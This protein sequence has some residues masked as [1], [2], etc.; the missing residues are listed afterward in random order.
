MATN[1]RS[2]V[3]TRHLLLGL[4]VANVLCATGVGIATNVATDKD[5]PRWLAWLD[6]G[7][8][9]WVLG[10]LMMTIIA[11]SVAL[12]KLDS[13]PVGARATSA[14]HDLLAEESLSRWQSA[15]REMG[16]FS[17]LPLPSKWGLEEENNG[18]T[19]VMAAAWGQRG[20][21]SPFT[22]IPG[23]KA[24]RPSDLKR[25]GGGRQ[26]HRIYGSLPS[27]RLIVLGDAGSGKSGSAVLLALDAL[28]HRRNQPKEDRFLVP[29]PLLLSPRTWHAK[30]TSTADWLA[31]H[32]ANEY[33]F[34]AGRDG[35]NE[36]EALVREGRVSL[37][38][39]GLDEI[40][41]EFRLS[42]LDALNK[43]TIRVVVLSRPD[44]LQDATGE[45]LISGAIAVR[46]RPFS[47]NTAAD[48]LR[49][50]RRTGHA[51][52]RWEALLGLLRSE[53]E[54]RLATAL[55]SPLA[56]GIVRDTYLPG[57]DA[58]ELLDLA[59]QGDE[60]SNKI[61]DHLIKRLIN[62]AYGSTDEETVKARRSLARIAHE[63][64]ARGVQEL[65][66][67]TIRD[68]SP[69]WP[70][71]IATAVPIAMAIFLGI[72]LG[73]TLGE[74]SEWW[75]SAAA[76]GVLA[77]AFWPSSQ[78]PNRA[79]LLNWRAPWFLLGTIAVAAG[80][81]WLTVW[82]FLVLEV[83]SDAGILMVLYGLAVATF[84]AFLL[85]SFLRWAVRN[86]TR[87]AVSEITEALNPVRVRRSD[88]RYGAAIGLVVGPAMA[89]AASPWASPVAS[90]LLGL[91]W[92]GVVGA[93]STQAWQA[94][95]AFMQMRL[96]WGTSLR[97]M[98]L[99][100]DAR[101]RA[102]L[103]RSVGPIYQFRHKK[104]QDSIAQLVDM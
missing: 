85:Q 67:W 12:W 1:K 31:S 55:N 98:N 61:A 73:T 95:L 78:V 50:S 96:R 2:H 103:V 20:R 72:E 94:N 22:P 42:L 10:I 45:R 47:G 6:G 63:M 49:L 52:E 62:F 81:M 29:V 69:K 102:A 53:P 37:I 15:A 27:G 43:A 60:D 38:L 40:P 28:A 64:N 65:E 89:V 90:L 100:E 104:L 18:A 11:I 84:D 14:L 4:A 75:V 58:G 9:W 21:S 39:D 19:G 25:G 23:L 26:L 17:P 3:D 82:T 54:G 97:V 59:A 76:S 79:N 34:L 92:G 74:L 91:I 68:W 57:D 30:F 13:A 32:L 86:V 33:Q 44:E 8:A 16:L 7:T 99:L 56:L 41:L 24:P 80:G 70:S 35:R 48:F 66:W 83:M 87:S 5:L 88:V 46:I 77:V 36:A 71:A 101:D 93:T 51:P